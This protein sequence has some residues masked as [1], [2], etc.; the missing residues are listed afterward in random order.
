MTVPT[1]IDPGAWLSKHLTGE[2]GD[3]DLARAMLAAFAETLMSAHASMMCFRA[4]AV[5]TTFFEF[6]FWASRRNF[7]HRRAWAAQ[8]RA[9]VSGGRPSWR[10]RSSTPTDGPC[11]LVG[12]G[13]LDE[14]SAQVQ[15]ARLGDVALA[16]LAAAGVLRG[17]QTGEAHER[18]GPA[19]PAPVAD[20]GRQAQRPHAGRQVRTDGVQVGRALWTTA[21]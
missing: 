17:H 7:P 3:G 9:T 12:P 16:G 8:A 4:T 1:T 2:D 15:V 18:T 19:E 21:R 5:A 6:F 10:R 11:L 14:L 13:R 20:L